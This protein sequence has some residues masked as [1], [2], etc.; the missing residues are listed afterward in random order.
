MADKCLLCPQ[1]NNCDWL[2]AFC[3]LT[4]REVAIRPLLI[5]GRQ[6]SKK[7]ER[8]IRK[9]IEGNRERAGYARL[10]FKKYD[11]RRKPDNPLRRKWRRQKERQK[12]ET[13]FCPRQ[14]PM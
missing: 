12:Q 6:R 8:A 4:D 7:Q 9:L 10:G 1:R 11:K 3:L 5:V 2:A 13:A 14:W